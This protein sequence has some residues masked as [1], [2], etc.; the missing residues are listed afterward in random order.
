M[1]NGQPARRKGDGG[2]RRGNYDWKPLGQTLDELKRVVI[3]RIDVV[4]PVPRSFAAD[5]P[6]PIQRS[7][8]RRALA[9]QRRESMMQ[10]DVSHLTP[11]GSDF[12]VS[13]FH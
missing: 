3:K 8:L 5:R 6:F 2:C 7:F 10:W 12:L 1:K 4:G 9:Y 13:R 11:T